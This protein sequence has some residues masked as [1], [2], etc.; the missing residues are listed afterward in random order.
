[1]TPRKHTRKRGTL[2]NMPPDQVRQLITW[3]VREVIKEKLETEFGVTVSLMPISNFARRYVMPVVDR[4]EEW[5]RRTVDK[6][7]AQ[8][9]DGSSPQMNPAIASEPT[10]RV[11]K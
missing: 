6:E 10:A 5:I 3:L 4:R 8:V 9:I 7:W 11:S 2:E 1:M